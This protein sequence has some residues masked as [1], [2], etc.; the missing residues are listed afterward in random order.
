[1]TKASEL[2]PVLIF[3][4]VLNEEQKNSIQ[5]EIYLN[6]QKGNKLADYWDFIEFIDMY[7]IDPNSIDA[8]LLEAGYETETP[9]GLAKF[10]RISPSDEVVLNMIHAPTRQS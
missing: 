9:D 5:F 3:D 7:G 6:G 8:A 10:V 1:M 4:N 2:K